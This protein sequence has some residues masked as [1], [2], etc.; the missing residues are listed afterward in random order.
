[1]PE[2]VA[3]PAITGMG[4]AGI[5]LGP[6]AIG[7]VARATSLSAVFLIVTLILVGV[8]ASGRLLRL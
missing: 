4:Y 8:A 1:M 2:G 7:L 3:I 5:L 6:A